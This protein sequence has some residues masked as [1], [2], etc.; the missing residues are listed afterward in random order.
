MFILLGGKGGEDRS[1][2]E[3]EKEGGREI[4]SNCSQEDIWNLSS[5]TD[6]S[7]SLHPS[8]QLYAPLLDEIS[9]SLNPER[10]QG[11]GEKDKSLWES[12]PIE[13]DGRAQREET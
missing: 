3:K 12:G 2:V 10:K 13:R 1:S 11:K 4:R 9:H 8:S 6:L 7:L 5:L